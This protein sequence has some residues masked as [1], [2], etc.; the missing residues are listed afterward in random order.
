M[1]KRT[2]LTS[3]LL[4][5]SLIAGLCAGCSSGQSAQS[6]PPASQTPQETQQVPQSGTKGGRVT[7]YSSMDTEWSDPFIKEFEEKTGI[8]VDVVTAGT[9]ELTARIEAE[10]ENPQ[11]DVLWAGDAG[12]ALEFQNNYLESYV[13]SED[14]YYTDGYKDSANHKWY[15]QHIEANIAVYNKN[16][17]PVDE[18]PTSWADLCDPKWA[19]KLYIPDPAK[20]TTGLN[21]LKALMY[22]MS[23]DDT[24]RYEWLEKFA[25]NLDG[26]V[27]SGSSVAYKAVVDGEYPIG[28]TYEE[29]AYRYINSGADIGVI[30]MSEG[31]AIA[32]TSVAL[33]K[34]GPNQDNGKALIDFLLGREAQEQINAIGRRT[35]R[36]DIPPAEGMPPL[37]DM[38]SCGFFDE[39]WVAENQTKIQEVFKEALIS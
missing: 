25:K 3:A 38:K 6:A 1:K 36:S 20:S 4:S 15:A 8:T 30:Y 13:S 17:V 26:V 28:F 37:A 39:T 22:A 5:L 11:C 12:N 7:I 9:G 19:G 24:V 33:V 27:A 16:L 14:E 21:H 31:V 35:A 32:R 10:K 2:K 18:V 29:A 23:D 34:G